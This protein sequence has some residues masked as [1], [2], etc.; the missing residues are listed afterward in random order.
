MNMSVENIMLHLLAKQ[1]EEGPTHAFPIFFSNIL[2][3]ALF[4]FQKQGYKYYLGLYCIQNLE[5]NRKSMGWPL[6][7]L[8]GKEMQHIIF[9][10]HVHACSPSYTD[11]E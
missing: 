10:A 9:Y 1:V 5:K 4:T 7:N 2:Y 8:F 3:C 6:H 11:E